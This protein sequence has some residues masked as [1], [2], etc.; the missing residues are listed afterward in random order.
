MIFSCGIPDKTNP[1]CSSSRH[2]HHLTECVRY[3]DT[4][5]SLVD[6]EKLEEN[7]VIAAENVRM[8]A[9]HLGMITGTIATEEVLSIIFQ[10][11][12]IGK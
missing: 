8:A 11:F 12:C 10:R 9:E 7:V 6:V 1:A 4:Y 5:L 3:L 2:R